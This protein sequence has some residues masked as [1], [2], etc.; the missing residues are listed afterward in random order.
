MGDPHNPARVGEKWN[1]ERLDVQLAE[2]EQLKNLTPFV[3]SGGWAWH[4]MSPQ[5]HEEVKI[6]HDHKDIDVFIKPNDFYNFMT[7]LKNRGFEKVKTRY[8]KGSGSFCRYTKFLDNGKIVFDVFIED[9]PS[10]ESNGFLVVPPKHLLPMYSIKKHT[11]EECV[12]VI[13]A[14]DLVKRGINPIGHKD[15]VDLNKFLEK[16]EAN[17]E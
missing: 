2:L 15:L 5:P 11:S 3:L 7:A 10:V 1:Q 13:T 6:F 12:A 4:F 9:M 14:R 16:Q 8:D 17:N